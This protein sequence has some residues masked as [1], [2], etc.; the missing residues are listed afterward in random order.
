MAMAAA[1]AI[2]VASSPPPPP[3]NVNDAVLPVVARRFAQ[4][5]LDHA[6]PPIGAVS[7]LK[8]RNRTDLV[9]GPRNPLLHRDALPPGFVRDVTYGDEQG[10]RLRTGAGDAARSN[11]TPVRLDVGAR[12]A[13]SPTFCRIS[14]I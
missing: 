1:A 13:R 14:A 11:R 8:I 12:R 9:V 4:L 3:V 7:T 10:A 5:D 6:V 2:V